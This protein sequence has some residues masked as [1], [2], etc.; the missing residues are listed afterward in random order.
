LP[1]KLSAIDIFAQ[2]PAD[3]KFLN[4]FLCNLRLHN[5]VDFCTGERGKHNERAS[6]QSG[7]SNCFNAQNIVVIAFSTARFIRRRKKC[8]QN[9]MTKPMGAPMLFKREKGLDNSTVSLQIS[10][11]EGGA[12]L[13]ALALTTLQKRL[14]KRTK[15][16]RMV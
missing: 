4:F 3:E 2:Q 7:L 5:G 13:V 8:E 11:S 10:L 1:E 9:T 6:A 16:H 15:S 12:S 14:Y